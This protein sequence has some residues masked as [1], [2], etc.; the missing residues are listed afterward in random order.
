VTNRYVGTLSEPNSERVLKIQTLVDS[1]GAPDVLIKQA[2]NFRIAIGDHLGA[3]PGSATGTYYGLLGR[4]FCSS[5]SVCSD[6]N[7]F[8]IEVRDSAGQP[9]HDYQIIAEDGCGTL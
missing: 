8:H 3:K 1:A 9:L 6:E 4:R 5:G 7:E 2:S